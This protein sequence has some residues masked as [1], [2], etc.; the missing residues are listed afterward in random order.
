MQRDLSLASL[1]SPAYPSFETRPITPGRPNTLI[2][3]HLHQLHLTQ[4]IGPHST[5]LPSHI[6]LNELT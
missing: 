5:R 6:H 2:G 3:G 1:L 4:E